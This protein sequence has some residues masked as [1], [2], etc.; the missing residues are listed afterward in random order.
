MKPRANSAPKDVALVIVLK[1][2][3]FQWGQLVNA[4]TCI[5][6]NLQVQSLFECLMYI[7]PGSKTSYIII[8]P[9]LPPTM[10]LSYTDRFTTGRRHCTI[11]AIPGSTAARSNG[12]DYSSR[13]T[14]WW[15]CISSPRV[16]TIDTNL[17][18]T[19]A[20]LVASPI[21]V[22]NVYNGSSGVASFVHWC[23]CLF[24]SLMNISIIGATATTR[25]TIRPPSSSLSPPTRTTHDARV[26]T[27]YILYWF[28][29]IWNSSAGLTKITF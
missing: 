20:R 15:N 18:F 28:S 7:V 24:V 5:G 26:C 14:T 10:L 22:D 6:G 19:H 1:F 29:I 25:R 21:K 9:W 12:A 23:A 4:T 17:P 11:R 3:R 27:F 13:R 8:G 2:Q 16:T